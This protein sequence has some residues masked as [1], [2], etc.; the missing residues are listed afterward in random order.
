[1]KDIDSAR[2]AVKEPLR[3]RPDI[4]EFARLAAWA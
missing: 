1:L 3:V 2:R 4:E